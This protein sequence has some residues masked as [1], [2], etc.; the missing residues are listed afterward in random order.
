MAARLSLDVLYELALEWCPTKARWN[1]LLDGPKT[2]GPAH[3]LGHALIEARWRWDIEG[4]D[5]CA[6]GCCHCTKWGYCTVYEAAAMYIS[7]GLLVAA[8]QAFLAEREIN[9]THDYDYI[10][11]YH[12]KRARN[13][14]RRKKLWPVPRSRRSLEAALKRRLGKPRGGPLVPK[15]PRRAPPSLTLLMLAEAIGGLR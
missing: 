14:L 6:L 2:W 5:H 8:G 1:H 4:Y 3:E 7:R 11:P 15:K 13:L 10:E 12:F 9:D